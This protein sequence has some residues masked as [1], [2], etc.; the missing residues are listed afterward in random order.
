MLHLLKVAR[1]HTLIA[2]ASV[3]LLCPAARADAEL[4]Q[5]AP[6]LRFMAGDVAFYSTM[7]R[8]REQVEA[9]GRSKA[10]ATLKNL[11]LVRALWHKLTLEI[12]KPGTPINSF[13]QFYQLPENRQMVELLADMGS[14]EIF[15]CGDHD[16]VGA[17]GLAMEL[18]GAARFGPALLQLTGQ[19]RGLDPAK[20]QGA[21]VLNTLSENLD[22]IKVPELTIGFKVSDAA[23]AEAQLARLEKLAQG[24]VQSNAQL[25]GRLKRHKVAGGDFLT[26]TLDGSMVPWEQVPFERFE[27]EPGQFDKLRE[28]LTSLKFGLSMGIREGY[29]LIC[30]DGTGHPAARFGR[31]SKL[32]DRPEFKRLTP[33]ASRRITSIGYVSQAM[34]AE[35]GTKKKDV[36]DWIAT[37]NKYLNDAGLPEEVRARARKDL[38]E[39]A[40]DVKSLIPEIGASLSFS[41][42]T[43]RGQESYSFEWGEHPSVD[44]SKPLSLLGHCGG[45]PILALVG[46]SK[47]TPQNY[48]LLVKWLKVAYGYVDEFVIP[49]LD[50]DKRE[51]YERFSKIAFPLLQRLDRTTAE[52]LLPALADGQAGLV[53]DAKIRSKQWIRGIPASDEALPMLEPAIIF[54]VSDAALLK[55]AMS[56]YRSIVNDA[57]TQVREAVPI[58]PAF[59]IPE[60]KTM[61]VKSG[62]LYFYPLPQFIGLDPQIVPNAGLSAHVAALTIS[63]QHSERLLSRTPLY[64]SGGPLAD[65]NR[66]LAGAF[67][68]DWPGFV[69]AVT[70][71]VDFGLHAAGPKPLAGLLDESEEGSGKGENEGEGLR[72]QVHAFLSVLK[73]LRGGTSAAY[74]EDGILVTH[75]ETVFKDL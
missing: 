16:W 66:P 23:R 14:E 42:L 74:L 17:S 44:S 75:S 61:K 18:L 28:K 72:K 11:P 45:N 2:V 6:S 37:A 59:E 54:G 65:A 43:D 39:L 70:P 49:R 13:W 33:F 34:R 48:R 27:T 25:Q 68:C 73:V 58:I 4:G 71:W 29:V 5:A 69:D 51:Q 8:N 53:L 35:L 56:D 40:K 55:Q 62:T 10:W 24:F 7:L 57:L 32:A 64:V 30:L 41:F 50:D 1:L 9:I 63:K 15:I 31:G 38:K 22:R 67:Y 46:R 20:L 21:T 3:S 60:P 36:D 52:R 26:L 47:Y 19:A 12:E